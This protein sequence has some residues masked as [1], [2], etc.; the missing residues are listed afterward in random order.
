MRGRRD[1]LL[2]VR[3]DGKEELWIG[4]L[5]GHPIQSHGHAVLLGAND[6][7]LTLHGDVGEDVND[8]TL[9]AHSTAA[10]RTA[11][12]I[13]LA[14]AHAMVRGVVNVIPVQGDVVVISGLPSVD[15][16]LTLK[17]AVH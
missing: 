13:A 11:H 12:A 6:V 14:N 9:G 15:G 7:A 1:V 8:L 10:C 3:I 5:D 2:R 17:S 16:V 4:V